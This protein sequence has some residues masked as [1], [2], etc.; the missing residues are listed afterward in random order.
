[1][2]S[3]LVFESSVWSQLPSHWPQCDHCRTRSLE[4][5]GLTLTLTHHLLHTALTPSPCH[6]HPCVPCPLPFASLTPPIPPLPCHLTTLTHTA[7][8]HANCAT[9]ATLTCHPHCP[10]PSPSP[11]ASL[12]LDLPCCLAALTPVALAHAN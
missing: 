12:M 11:I 1:M 4:H 3:P 10:H 6:P 5:L 8:T 2:P 7:L 9:L